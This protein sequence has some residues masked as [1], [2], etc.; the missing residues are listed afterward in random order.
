MLQFNIF[1]IP[2]TVQPF[3]W[4]TLAILGSGGFRGG[5][6]RM[7]LLCMALFV[8]AGFISILVHELGH[9]LT[10]RKFGARCHIVLEAFGGYAAYA[11]IA[12]SRLQSFLIT[13]AGPLFQIIFGFLIFGIAKQLPP[14]QPT[15][16]YFIHQLIVISWVWAAFNLLPI[17]PLD[18]GRL[19]ES[20]LGPHRIKTTLWV[21]II[22]AVSVG[23]LLFTTTRSI[24]APIFLGMFAW[25]AWKTLQE[26]HWR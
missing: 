26:N 12:M 8:L 22:T 23:I 24:F 20:V 17:L 10:A 9:A 11:G 15:A 5:D 4:I 21:T 7:A 13:A 1:G 18:G 3:F 25:Q 6:T 14:L 19:L 2:V 16:D